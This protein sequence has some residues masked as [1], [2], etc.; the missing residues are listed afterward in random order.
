MLFPK[1]RLRFTTTFKG[2]DDPE[3]WI[4]LDLVGAD[5]EGTGKVYL[6]MADIA[7]LKAGGDAAAN[8]LQ[9]AKNLLGGDLDETDSNDEN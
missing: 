7:A 5:L 4:V 1:K 2:K 6:S 8:R 3:G 9:R